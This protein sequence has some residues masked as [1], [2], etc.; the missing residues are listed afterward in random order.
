MSGGSGTAETSAGLEITCV[1][2]YI[3]C[4]AIVEFS[5]ASDF[6]FT[7][8]IDGFFDE[9]KNFSTAVLNEIEA[10]V[11]DFIDSPSLESLNDVTDIK[12]T[13]DFNIAVPE[14]SESEIQI[15]LENLDLY[16]EL[17]T[18]LTRGAS[19]TLN[20]FTSNTIFGVRIAEGIEAGAFITLDLILSAIN[21]NSGFHISLD[22]AVFNMQLFS[23]EIANL[24]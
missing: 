18:R 12:V 14:V 22:Q 4:D 23:R 7:A 16:V 2:C 19:Y 21:I 11:G 9:L 24:A 5:L 13:E 8:Y 3:K 10:D 15:T 20:L 6:N 17:E 1:R